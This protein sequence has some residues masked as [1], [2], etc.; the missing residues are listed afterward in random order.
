MKKIKAKNK[1]K[2]ITKLIMLLT[3]EEELMIFSSINIKTKIILVLIMEETLI[4][5]MIFLMMVS[6]M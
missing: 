5:L 2:S 3:R 6:Q 1:L 4:S